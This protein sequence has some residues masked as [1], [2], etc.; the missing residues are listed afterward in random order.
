MRMVRSQA[1]EIALSRQVIRRQR[2]ARRFDHHA[3]SRSRVMGLTLPAELRA[4][5]VAH[6]PKLV[7]LGHA[8]YE[9]EHDAYRSRGRRAVKRA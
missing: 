8:G 3:Q 4:N 9:R 1:E 6:G 5:L 2:R 7:Q